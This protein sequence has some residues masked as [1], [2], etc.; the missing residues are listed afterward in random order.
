[1]VVIITLDMQLCMP[2]TRVW[3]TGDHFGAFGWNI[4]LRR[5][6]SFYCDIMNIITSI[7]TPMVYKA[8]RM[9]ESNGK[10]CY[11]TISLFD[12]KKGKLLSVMW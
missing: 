10:D 1:M 4:N 8:K 11:G 5:E 7:S 9:F 12:Q 3:D 2:P 6:T